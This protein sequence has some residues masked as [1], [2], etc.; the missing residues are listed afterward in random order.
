MPLKI[1]KK[2]DELEFGVSSYYKQGLQTVKNV[3]QNEGLRDQ[4]LSNL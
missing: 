3:L 1:I 2:K 4:L